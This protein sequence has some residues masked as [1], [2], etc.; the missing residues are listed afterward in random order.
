[1][2]LP[3]GYIAPI[4]AN[5]GATGGLTPIPATPTLAN[6]FGPCTTLLAVKRSDADIRLALLLCERHR[7]RS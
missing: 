4:P 1:M 5:A 3:P 6:L 7:M 2:T